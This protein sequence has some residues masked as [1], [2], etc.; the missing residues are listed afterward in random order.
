[1][2]IGII[3]DDEITRIELAKLLNVRGYETVLFTAFENLAAEFAENSVE[4][5]LLDINL[6]YENGYE[7]CKKIKKMAQV[8]VI[9]VTSRDTNVDELHSIQAGGIDFIT[10]PY[11]TLIL[12]EKIKRDL[13]LSDPNNFR[14]IVKKDCT[15]DL[16]LS[17][18]KYKDKDIE[19]TRNEFRILYYFFMND[20]KIIGK[21]ELLEKLWNDKYYLDE[22][23]LLVNMSRLKKKMRDIGIVHLLENVR[24]KGWKL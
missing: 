6:P 5:L 17:I 1:M 18:L 21:E 3:E 14:E 16:H 10:K 8:P 13:K 11:D 22:N 15:L 23:V 20:D 12:L 19:L 24:G 4:L 9:F 2:R 7:V